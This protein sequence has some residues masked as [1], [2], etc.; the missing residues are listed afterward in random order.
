ME[1]GNSSSTTENE[2][3]ISDLPDSLIHH[4]LSFMR[5]IKFAVQTCVLSTRWR[6]IWTSLPVL[7]FRDESHYSESESDNEDFDYDAARITGRFIKFVD[8]VLSLRDN[9]SDILKFHFEYT[10]SYEADDKLDN[11]INRCI[12]TAVSHNVQEVYIETSLRKDFEIPLCLC[13]CKSLTK[14]EV[15]WSGFSY[16][17]VILPC[18]MNLPRLKLLSLRLEDLVFSDEKLTNQFFSSFP[19]LESLVIDFPG[20][21]HKCGFRDMNLK[22]SLPKL[23]YFKFGGLDYEGNSEI[24]LH[25]PSL[26]SFIF[27][28]DMVTSFIVE[29]LPSLVT[30]DIQICAATSGEEKEFYAQRV[31]GLLGGIHFVKVLT[32]K[33][34]FLENLELQTCLLGDCLRSLLYILKSSPNIESVSLRISQHDDEPQL[35]EYREKVESYPDD[36]GGDYSDAEL[37][38]S[39][40]ICH[41]KFVEINGICGCADELKFLEILLKHATVLEKLVLTSDPTEDYQQKKRMVKFSETLLKF[42]T[43][44]KKILIFLKS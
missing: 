15:V 23:K 33:F 3:R 20:W 18:E 19:N 28:S 30:A 41:L 5:D 27:E 11:C 12:A 38:L 34:S 9:N 25:A 6:Y 8:K 17:K 2:D 39:C 26:S 10:P 21:S 1:R 31:M 16:S 36:I 29:D 42:P 24:R 37:S 7:K 13:T 44:S 22:I 4:I 32:L 14:L 40:M 43:A 35:Y